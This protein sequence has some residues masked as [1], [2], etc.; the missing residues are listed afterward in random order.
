MRVSMADA[1]FAPVRLL[2]EVVHPAGAGDDPGA[3]QAT[4]RVTGL[5]VLDL[6]DVGAPVGEH[7]TGRGNERPRRQFDDADPAENV[8]HRG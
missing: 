6:D 7:G 1:A 5:G 2:D 8:G 4:L 3:D